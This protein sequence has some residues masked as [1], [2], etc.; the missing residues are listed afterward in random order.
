M[1]EIV[2]RTSTIVEAVGEDPTPVGKAMV[3]T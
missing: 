3:W 1:R 2:G